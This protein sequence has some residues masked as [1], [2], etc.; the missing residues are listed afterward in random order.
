MA[1]FCGGDGVGVDLLVIV[2]SFLFLFLF[3]L[4]FRLVWR[5][6]VTRFKKTGVPT[7]LAE[8]EILKTQSFIKIRGK[9]TNES[10]K[11]K[12]TRKPTNNQEKKT[13]IRFLH[14]LQDEARIT[15]R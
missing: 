10:V 6:S 5:D 12:Q 3:F 4:L 9:V 14:E 8:T 2:F 15:I 1:P 13:I 7:F 11:I